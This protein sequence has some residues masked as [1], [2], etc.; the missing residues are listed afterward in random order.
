[1][2]DV[3]AVMIRIL[4]LF[5]A[6]RVGS[7]AVMIRATAWKWA[8]FTTFRT[9]MKSFFVVDPTSL[10]YFQP[11]MMNI[12]FLNSHVGWLSGSWATGEFLLKSNNAGEDWEIIQGIGGRKM[13]FI[14]DKLALLYGQSTDGYPLYITEDGW[15]TWVSFRSQYNSLMN[16]MIIVDKN[17]CWGVGANGMIMELKR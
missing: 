7:L 13:S 4:F 14:N 2:S 11:R 16:A 17:T 15:N 6:R 9:A 12:Y 8:F 5:V 1:M 10:K 3:P